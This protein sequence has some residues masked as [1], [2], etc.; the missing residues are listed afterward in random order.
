MP[1]A[2]L[3]VMG[4][5]ASGKTTVGR[6]L[7]ARLGW[8]FFDG[9]DYHSPANIARM[10]AGIPLT[11]EDRA[12]WLARLHDLL[13]RSLAEGRQAVLAC[14]AL[15]QR[16]REALLAG[17]PGVQVVY[18]KG[19]YDLI[20]ARMRRR[21]AHYM[22]PEM[23]RSQFD[24]L[25][26]PAEAWIVE[27]EMPPEKIVGYILERIKDGKKEG[28][29]TMAT[30]IPHETDVIPTPAGDL[31]ITFLGHASLEF[32]FGGKEIYLDPFSRLADYSKLP[33][34]DILFLTHEHRDHL[35]PD[36]IVHLRTEKTLVVLTAACAG[37]VTGGIVMKNG[38][39]RSVGGLPVEAVPAYN[40]LHKR[41]NGQPFHPKG[42]GNGYL[43]TI[44]GLRVYIAGDTENIP[45]MKSLRGID[46]AFLPMNL[47][48]TMTPEMAADAARAFR[49]RILYPYHFG[50]TDV[51]KLEQL[52]KSEKGIELRVRKMA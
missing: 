48:Y 33:K 32:A 39:T 46:I 27:V 3:L 47:P 23:L 51:T 21:P 2:G 35:D 24:A 22:K 14:S 6:M 20:L 19:S 7:S 17:I 42:D 1:T 10:S 5:S 15:K 25:E 49:P 16:Y 13:A 44:G 18:L 31:K 29:T 50:D 28:G 4:V 11:D 12:P 9:D 26:A 37:Q 52:L 43:L 34:A 41:E 38:D 30:Q 40:L 8:E 45:E 36:A